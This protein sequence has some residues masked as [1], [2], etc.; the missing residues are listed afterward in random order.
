MIEIQV[1]ETGIQK[2]LESLSKKYDVTLNREES[3]F[4]AEMVC[5]IIG[6]ATNISLLCLELYKIVKDKKKVNYK[7]ETN[8]QEGMTLDKASKQAESE[9]E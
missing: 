4:D 3:N 9:C 7:S 2:E 8:E 6:A 5:S 1:D